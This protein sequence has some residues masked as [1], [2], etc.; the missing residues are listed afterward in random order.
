MW[1]TRE[2]ASLIAAS[3]GKEIETKDG[4][5]EINHGRWEQMTRAEVEAKF[6]DEY[7]TWEADP[8][9]FAPKLAG[10]HI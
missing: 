10:D 3:H 1:R 4:L 2:T 6:P 7:R 8:F 5:R 9:T